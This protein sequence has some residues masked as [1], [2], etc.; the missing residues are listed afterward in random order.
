MNAIRNQYG[1]EDKY[2]LDQVAK[3]IYGLQAQNLFAAGQNYDTS[4]DKHNDKNV[5]IMFKD[6]NTLTG[7]D[8]TL[9]YDLEWSGYKPTTEFRNRIGFEFGLYANDGTSTWLNS[10]CYPSTTSGKKTSIFYHAHSR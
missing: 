4:V 6:W 3:G 1:T 10:W 9:S 2:T 8:V 5:I 7:K